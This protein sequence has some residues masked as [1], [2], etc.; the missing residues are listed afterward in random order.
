MKINL[1]NLR[2]FEGSNSSHPITLNTV[3]QL[4][5]TYISGSY[6]ASQ[7]TL[8]VHTLKQHGILEET[9]NFTDSPKQ[10]LNS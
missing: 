5:D 6:T 7:A 8:I 10:Q 2:K 9:D 1:D 4:V 3:Q